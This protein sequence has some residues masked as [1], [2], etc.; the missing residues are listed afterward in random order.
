MS[1]TQRGILLINLGSPDSPSVG[2]VRRYLKQFLMDER[3][4][5]IPLLLR[6][7]VV[8][9]FILP[10]RPRGSAE[11]YGSIW[12]EDGAPLVAISR[13]V[14]TLVQ[15]GS[16]LPVTLGMRY[17]NPSIEN[18]LRELL[19]NRGERIDEILVV[20]LYPHYAMSTTESAVEEVRRTLSRMKAGIRLE[21]LPPF[22]DRADYIDALAQSMSGYTE[23]PYDHLLFSYHG[24]PE[25][26]L[27]KT[28]PTGEHCLSSEDCCST[29]SA[30][31][32]TC[33]RHQVL[34]TTERVVRVLGVPE[35]K[36]S[37]AFQSRL[38]RD[39]W[40]G[41]Y[42]AQETIRLARSGVKN[43]LVVCPSFVTD[44]LETLEEIG[45]RARRSFLSSGGDVLE[46]I[47]CLNDHP[48]WISVLRTWCRGAEVS[49]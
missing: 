26:H 5:D 15:E 33:Y 37:V 24:L 11:A 12:R 8:D 18:A 34:R 30:A 3:V 13:R 25:R 23:G 4:I 7:V 35:G 38:G 32:N 44:C 20:P 43:L 42:T 36:Y 48:A 14:M 31:H 41:P 9:L 2:D 22:F 17:G 1:S 27:K 47:P 45:V 29:P 40:L 16:E 19:D 6:K 10:F 49:S 28:D 46:L 21:V 39:A